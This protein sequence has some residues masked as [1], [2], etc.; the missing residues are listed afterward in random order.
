MSRWMSVVVVVVMLAGCGGGA[1]GD[2]AEIANPSATFCGEQGGVYS[3]E[4]ETCT[5]PDGSV[6]DAWD[7]YRSQTGQ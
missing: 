6:V 2:D 4:D 5:L 3:L 7:Y 1:G